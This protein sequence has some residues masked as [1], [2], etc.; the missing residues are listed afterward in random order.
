MSYWQ[1]GLTLE[2]LEELAIKEAFKFH[3]GNKSAT[4]R[5]LDISVRT[6]ETKLEKYENDD[7]N[8]RDFAAKRRSNEADFLA[9]S[10]GQS[11]SQFAPSATRDEVRSSSPRAKG[12]DGS[13]DGEESFA[14]DEASIGGMGVQSAPESSSEHEVSLPLRKEV[15]GVP[16]KRASGTRHR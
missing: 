5:A 12:K 2:N 13:Q 8:K 3:Q 6:L 15:Q 11:I 1:P 10:R 4:A 16:S 9:R 14:S 7:R